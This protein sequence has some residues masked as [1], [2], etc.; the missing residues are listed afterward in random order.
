MSSILDALKKAE[1]ESTSDRGEGTPW[2][3]PLSGNSSSRQRT[4][5]WQVALGLVVVASVAG[6]VFWQ[7][8]RPGTARPVVTVTAPAS[9]RTPEKTLPS[10]AG[11]PK[12]GAAAAE[13]KQS[14]T[15][16]AV[17]QVSAPNSK[18]SVPPVKPAQEPPREPA[19][20]APSPVPPPPLPLHKTRRPAAKMKTEPVTA[21]PVH[22]PA[23]TPETKPPS[24]NAPSDSGKIFRNDPRIDL[25]ALVWAQD[26]DAR[27]VVINNRLVKEGDSVDTIVV[28]RINQDDVLLAEGSDKWHEEFKV[29]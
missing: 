19:P 18:G 13:K 25:Q 21:P 20:A 7:F 29:R 6:A 27:F 9:H 1:Q 24:T 23:K 11:K 5:R 26:A 16:T 17:P 22:S 3:A 10:V 8:R 15:K 12:P 2:P 4:R 28:V 14:R